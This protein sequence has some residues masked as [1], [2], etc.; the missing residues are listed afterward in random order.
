MKIASC[1]PEAFYPLRSLVKGPFTSMEDLDR[2]ERF[3]RT[4]VLHDEIVMDPVPW[5]YD[6]EGAFEFSEEEKRTGGRSVIVAIGPVLTGFDFFGDTP[7][8]E[9]SSEIQL[10]PALLKLAEQ[11]ANAGEGN[12]YFKA[13]VDYLK[14]LLETVEKG[15][16]LLLCNEFGEQIT[17]SVRRYP[18][19]LFKHLDED[20]KL[21]A[22]DIERDGLNLLTPPLLSIVLT[23]CAR[24]D[25]IPAVIRDLRDE[26]SGARKK[27]WALLDALRTSRT[28]IE[29]VEL[30]RELSEASK[31]FS[32]SNPV[33][34][35]RPLRVFWEIG[36]AAGAGSATAVLS[37]GNPFIGA[38]T[39]MI[40]QA[41]RSFP[42]LMQE[43]GP[44]IFGRGAFD[45]AQKVR[46]EIAQVE[47][48][49]L[50]RLLSDSEKQMLGLK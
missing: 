21:Y 19:E 48:D 37:G 32:P 31:L 1:D 38:A 41:A 33:G 47:L 29:A 45:L 25:A 16:S 18:E 5:S 50:Q 14:R 24:R 40:G 23:R 30:R 22:K 44:T 6:P 3:I 36:A 13:H 27:V 10:S 4:V 39:N 34:Q 7:Y 15:G 11:Y 9:P 17:T 8:R 2:V 26:W 49:S 20:W 42:A 43:F 28:L 35:T 12:V 46:K